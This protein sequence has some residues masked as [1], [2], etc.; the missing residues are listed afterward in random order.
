MLQAATCMSGAKLHKL[1]ELCKSPL[2]FYSFLCNF[3]IFVILSPY[4]FA[5]EALVDL[6]VLIAP[7]A[8]SA[9][10]SLLR[11]PV[12]T[13]LRHYAITSLRHN[14][15]PSSRNI[16]LISFL[17]FLIP[18]SI[19]STLGPHPNHIVIFTLY[20]RFTLLFSALLSSFCHPPPL[21]LLSKRTLSPRNFT[22]YTP[23][24]PHNP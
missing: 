6:V 23:F 8:L 19:N 16:R 20:S 3:V 24:S 2:T 18:S 13:P 5:L 9:W 11:H 15:T 10:L 17:S 7:S 12:I 4:L 22:P 14:A 21:S 1:F